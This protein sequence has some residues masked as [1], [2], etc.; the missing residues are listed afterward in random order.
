MGRRLHVAPAMRSL[1]RSALSRSVVVVVALVAVASFDAACAL[2]WEVTGNEATPPRELTEQPSFGG[3]STAVPTSS[4]PVVHHV[5]VVGALSVDA[6]TSN[7]AAADVVVIPD[8]AACTALCD[9]DGDGY[10][11]HTREGCAEA[12]G[13]QDCDDLDS[14][15]HPNQ[16]Y[17]AYAASPPR[18][19]DW[20][21]QGTVEKLHPTNVSCGLLALGACA[22]VA[23]FQGDP[24]CGTEGTYVYCQAVALLCVAGSPTTRK[25]ECK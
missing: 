4:P 20:N 17:V 7:D 19:G 2:D 10:P 22:G 9:C 25:Q 1:A 16:G 15:T 21:C 5:A 8:A 6:G 3:S 18:N 14:R 23:G 11:D 12:P 24:P 13:E